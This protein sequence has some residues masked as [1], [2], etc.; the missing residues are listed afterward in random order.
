MV[1]VAEGIAA[2]RRVERQRCRGAHRLT[3]SYLSGERN[4]EFVVCLGACL[5]RH[6]VG[7][8][9]DAQ[10]DS[11]AVALFDTFEKRDLLRIDHQHRHWLDFFIGG[12]CLHDR[13]LGKQ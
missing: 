3:G 6:V 10:T 11:L 8:G 5:A 4:A 2:V 12:F 9:L 1:G 7:H 13:Y